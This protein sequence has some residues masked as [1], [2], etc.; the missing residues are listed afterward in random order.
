MFSNIIKQYAQTY[1]VCFQRIEGV[2]FS[3]QLCFSQ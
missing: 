3:M 1:S 2:F